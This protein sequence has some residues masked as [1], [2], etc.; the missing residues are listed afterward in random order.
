MIAVAVCIHLGS[1]MALAGCSLA[2]LSNVS[3]ALF[4][5]RRKPPH[6]QDPVPS[7]TELRF[8]PRYAWAV[9]VTALVSG[10]ACLAATAWCVAQ[11]A[12]RRE[13]PT[14]VKSHWFAAVAFFFAFHALLALVKDFAPS[15]RL[16]RRVKYNG[17]EESLIEENMA[18]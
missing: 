14:D 3:V 9:F 15:L 5:Y 12:R 8:S 16:G 13:R 7:L 18:A 6:P 17:Q 4:L 1:S 2:L 10:L 11:G